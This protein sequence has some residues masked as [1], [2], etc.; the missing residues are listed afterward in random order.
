M[1]SCPLAT[2][3]S[4]IAPGSPVPFNI[5]G[6]DR[7]LLLARGQVIRDVDQLDAL[8][9]RGALVDA[10]EIKSPRAEVAEA[11]IEQLP[12]LWS[13]CIDRVGRALRQPTLPEFAQALQD[14][15][16]PVRRHTEQRGHG[17]VGV[18]PASAL[19][20][21]VSPEKLVVLAGR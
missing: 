19:R 20:V 12:A 16:E 3:R 5:R 17:V 14:A 18:V 8:F 4:R 15:A 1:T 9:D 10:D 21:R 2:G 11:Q 13:G 7:T 6:P